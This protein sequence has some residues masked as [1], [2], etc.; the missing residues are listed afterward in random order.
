MAEYNKKCRL[1]HCDN[2][3]KY[4]KLRLCGSHYWQ[5]KK[6]ME[7]TPIKPRIASSGECKLEFCSKPARTHGLCSSHYAQELRGK[8][9]KPLRGS[10]E[11]DQYEPIEIE[12]HDE[13]QNI[14]IN[15]WYKLV[16]RG[17]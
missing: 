9:L 4:K 2:P 12:K 7:F 5:Y 1:D 11:Y 17:N 16:F 14:D 15:L 13:H 8:H 10:P 6:G 3:M